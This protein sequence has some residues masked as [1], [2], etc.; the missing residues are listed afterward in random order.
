[1]EIGIEFR[2]VIIDEKENIISEIRHSYF[3]NVAGRIKICKV[4]ASV[5]D[6]VLN[7]NIPFEDLS[8]GYLAEWD[9]IPNN[10][11]NKEFISHIKTFWN[12]YVSI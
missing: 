6:E 7:G 3:D 4:R 12:I 8:I 10:K 11:Y 1:M 2:F 9:R 5:L